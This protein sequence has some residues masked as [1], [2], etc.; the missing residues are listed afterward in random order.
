MRTVKPLLEPDKYDRVAR[1]ALEFEQGV[2][3]RLNRYLTLKS[4]ISSNYVSDWWEEYVYLRGRSPIMVNSNYYALDS[5]YTQPTS[6][7]AARAANCI[8]V[9]FAYRRHLD[10]ETLEPLMVQDKVPLC[11]RQYERQFNTSRVPGMVGDKIVHYKDS[12]HVAVYCKGKWYKLYTYY[13]S[14]PLNAKE[15]EM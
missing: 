7:Q 4:Y 5:L 12:K 11:S 14:Q 9:A 1:E 15:L 3:R 8:V 2:G 6:I 13:N 10:N